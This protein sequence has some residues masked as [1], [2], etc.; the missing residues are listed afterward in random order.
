MDISSI[1]LSVIFAE[2]LLRMLLGKVEENQPYIYIYMTD[3]NSLKKK[4]IAEV[5]LQVSQTQF[6]PIKPN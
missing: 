2:P 3:N 5:S 4:S 6:L 1:I